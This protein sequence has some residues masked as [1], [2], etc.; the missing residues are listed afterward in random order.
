MTA[1]VKRASP[2]RAQLAPSL[3]LAAPLLVDGQIV[4]VRLDGRIDK[5]VVNS[6]L[7]GQE[8]KVRLDDRILNVPLTAF[9][10]ALRKLA[11]DPLLGDA[12]QRAVN[13]GKRMRRRGGGGISRDKQVVAIFRAFTSRSITVYEGDPGDPDPEKRGAFQR[14]GLWQALRRDGPL[15]REEAYDVVGPM[16]GLRS[17]AVKKIVGKVG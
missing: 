12:V 4:K 2:K 11:A 13:E 9:L 3:E 16:F 15:S 14:P 7:E 10:D 5:R 6:G 8:V 1:P 17:N